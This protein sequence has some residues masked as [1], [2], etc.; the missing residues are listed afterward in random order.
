MDV[1][2]LANE[3][4]CESDPCGPG[5]GSCINTMGSYRCR[6]LHGY[7]LLVHHG[8]L[9][10]IDV[11]EC[12]KPHTC[13]EGGQCINL[14][15]SYKCECFKGYRSKS[16]RQ[17]ICEDI[18]ECLDPRTCPNAQCENTPGSY[19]CVPCLPGHQAQGGVCYGRNCD[20]PEKRL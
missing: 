15:G 2:Q 8:K 19:E 10:C 1:G 20:S 4:E 14:P 13:G 18:N 16:P 7:K 12:Y 3:N 9:K 17:P 6:C 5:R 11:N